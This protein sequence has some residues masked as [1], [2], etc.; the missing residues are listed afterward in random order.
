MLPLKLSL[1]SL[2]LPK[3]ILGYLK[4]LAL[5]NIKLVGFLFLLN[6]PKKSKYKGILHHG[7]HSRVKSSKL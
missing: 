2:G 3:I 5:T 6:L 7:L 4:L 1:K